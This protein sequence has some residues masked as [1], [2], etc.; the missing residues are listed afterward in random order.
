MPD[1]MVSAKDNS[2]VI[3]AI[4]KQ[5]VWDWLDVEELKKDG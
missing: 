1:F 5:Q 3:R 4:S 2:F